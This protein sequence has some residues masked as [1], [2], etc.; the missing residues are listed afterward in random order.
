M[1]K[2]LELTEES[3]KLGYANLSERGEGCLTGKD[4]SQKSLFQLLL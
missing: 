2:C 3:I 1:L 4:E